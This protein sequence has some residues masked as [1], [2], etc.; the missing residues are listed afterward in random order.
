[1]E[2][3][4]N[5]IKY[6]SHLKRINIGR[7]IYPITGLGKGNRLGIW[8]RGCNLGCE[9]CMSKDLWEFDDKSYMTIQDIYNTILKY[10]TKI[11]GVTISG[12]EP[13]LQ[14]KELIILIQLIKKNITNDIIIYSGFNKKELK[15]LFLNDYIKLK[16]LVSVI[17]TGRYEMNLNHSIGLAGSINQEYIICDNNYDLNYLKNYK[18]KIDIV[19]INKTLI[20]IGILNNER[21]NKSE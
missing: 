4:V 19:S 18:R 11:D 1:M 20:L 7:I 21:R 13:F 6:E 15:E 3:F 16:S 17:I 12:G 9:E 10:K 14:I 5:I 8:V 2:E